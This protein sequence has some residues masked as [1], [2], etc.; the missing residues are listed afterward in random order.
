MSDMKQRINFDALPE[1]QVSEFYEPWQPKA[2]GR[3]RIR[4]SA[5]CTIGYESLSWAATN[6]AP[7]G[8]EHDWGANGM[9]GVV[10]ADIKG[11]E[12]FR[13][14]YG[15][16]PVLLDNYFDIKGRSYRAVYAAAIELTPIPEP[17]VEGC[18]E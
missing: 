4:F 14:K 9:T 17:V 11:H 12:E 6:D 1:T 13:S 10:R 16:Y 3:V 8:H 18:L 2:G 7:V 15:H 5:E